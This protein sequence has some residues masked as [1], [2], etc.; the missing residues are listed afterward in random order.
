L[1]GRLATS[2]TLGEGFF[3]GYHIMILEDNFS[4]SFR[5]LTKGDGRDGYK[6]LRWQWRL[7]QRFYQDDIPKVCDLPTGMG[8]TSVIHLW[9]LA[10][11]QQILENRPRLPTRL[12]YVVD[13]RTVVDQAT[14]IAEGAKRNLPSLDLAE[15]WLSVSTLRGQFA[16]NREWTINP[17]RPAIVIGME[18]E[19]AIALGRLGGQQ[20]Q[21]P[22]QLAAIGFPGGVARDLDRSQIVHARAAQQPVIPQESAGLDDIDGHAQTGRQAQQGPAVLRNIGLK[23]SEA[24]GGGALLGKIG[25]LH[26]TPRPGEFPNRL[27]RSRARA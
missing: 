22:P 24:H 17:S 11:R 20:D 1:Q 25:K 18:G 13:R 16:D 6:P 2:S 26:Y 3:A 14:Q 23:Q 15:D 27:P 9:L 19:P 12:V 5:A 4:S 21:P 7:F 10:L 8:K